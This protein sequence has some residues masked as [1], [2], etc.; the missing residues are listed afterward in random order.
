MKEIVA[1]ACMVLGSAGFWLAGY[2]RGL[3]VGQVRGR[4]A[5]RKLERVRH[6]SQ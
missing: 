5:Y 4:I 1:I 6:E 2:M 3:D